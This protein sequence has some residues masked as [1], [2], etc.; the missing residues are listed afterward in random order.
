MIRCRPHINIYKGPT[1]FYCLERFF[2]RKLCDNFNKYL[3]LP[4]NENFDLLIKSYEKFEKNTCIFQTIKSSVYYSIVRSLNIFFKSYEF[5]Y[6]SY[7][8]LLLHA[9]LND[10]IRLYN[11]LV[12]KNICLRYY[13]RKNMDDI[14]EYCA[15]YGNVNVMREIFADINPDG[16]NRQSIKYIE[17]ACESGN[18][19]IIKM[20]EDYFHYKKTDWCYR[21]L[22]FV[23]YI[24]KNIDI[25]KY[26]I[27]NGVDCNNLMYD[28]TKYDLHH[29]SVTY[30][31]LINLD[32]VMLLCQHIPCD[33]ITFEYA[34]Q[35]AT[36]HNLVDIINYINDNI[37]N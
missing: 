5:E 21:R 31:P 12:S 36:K 37:L 30:P 4:N 9:C 13:A 28:L 16:Y 20:I 32:L 15:F 34:L 8:F 22:I 11:F 2:P 24:F 3:L 27:E 29:D 33:H 19:E 7:R 18:L 10:D 17:I 6:Y 25:V 35:Y 26:F 23:A 14:L 1:N